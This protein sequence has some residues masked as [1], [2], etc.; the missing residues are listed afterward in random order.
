MELAR[1]EINLDDNLPANLKR[2]IELAA[3]FTHCRLQP[4]HLQLAIRSAMLLAF[5]IKNYSSATTFANRLLESG[6]SQT[7]A[8]Q[9]IDLQIFGMSFI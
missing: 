2:S 6:A 3:Y 8:A 7:I 4:V 5:K 9:V 1:R